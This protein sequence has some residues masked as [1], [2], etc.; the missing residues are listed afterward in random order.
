MA[1]IS[2][3]TKDTSISSG[4]K[5]LGSDSSGDTR[6]F[7][8]GD[9]TKFI[10]ETGTAGSSSSFTYR[11]N[12][13]TPSSGQAKFTISSGDTFANVTSIKVSKYNYNETVNSVDNALALLAGKT[14]IIYEIDNKNNFGV[15]SVESFSQ[16]GN[17]NFYN[18]SLTK[19][20]SNGS[21]VNDKVYGIDIFPESG[22]DKTYAHHQNNASNTWTINHNLAKFPSVSIK[23]S[24]SDNVYTNV[25]A[26]AGVVYTD[27]NNLTINLAAAESGYAYLN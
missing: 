13:G 7:V 21:V 2:T 20:T 9:V 15:Y 11:S 16:D 23:F 6:N 1:R 14:I 22:G 18:L 4:D 8:I 25:G 26:F 12:N 10:A 5:L 24:S 17:S 19:K 27:E 3:Y